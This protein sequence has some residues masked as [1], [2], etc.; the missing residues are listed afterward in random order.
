MQKIKNLKEK[1]IMVNK[2]F[3]IE[4]LITLFFITL[5]FFGKSFTK[6]NIIGP[7]YLHDFCLIIITILSLNRGKLRIRFVSLLILLCIAF[8]YLVI[9]LTFFNLK[10]EFLLIAFRQFSLF[11]YMLFAYLIFNSIILNKNDAHKPIFLIKLIA[12]LSVYLQVAYLLIGYLFVES[13]SIF[14]PS[15]YNYFSP[16][17]VL[18]I[19]VYSALTLAYERN[20]V[21]RFGKYIFAILLSTTLGHSSAFLAVLMV[22]VAYFFIHITFKQKIIAV[23]IASGLILL[24]FFLPQFR[25]ANAGWRLLYWKHIL[26]ESV[27][28]KYLLFGSGFGKPFMTQDYALY[29]NQKLGSAIMIEEQYPLA[30]YLSPPHNSILTIVFHIGLIPALLFFVPLKTFFKQIFIKKFPADNNI[31]FLVLALLGCIIWVCFN[32]VLELPHS[33]TYFWLIYFATVFYLKCYQ[34]KN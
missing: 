34:G 3:S 29:I 22:V 21:W 12:Y 28:T 10:G 16:L 2:I 19:I 26:T 5:L 31:I 32:V 30:S 14:Q 20:L 8:L 4:S 25:D 13:F 33:S 15:D 6:Y 7:I 9:S 23:G 24:L 1:E 27:Q 18:G 11:T 17:T